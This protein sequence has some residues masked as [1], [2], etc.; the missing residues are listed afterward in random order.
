MCPVWTP[1]HQFYGTDTSLE[2]L[3]DE[4]CCTWIQS[5]L[6]IAPFFPP[7]SI[8]GWSTAELCPDFCTKSWKEW[9]LSLCW[10]ALGSDVDF[11][12]PPGPFFF[13]GFR[14]DKH[15]LKLHHY[16]L[17]EVCSPSILGCS[18]AFV[19]TATIKTKTVR[20]LCMSFL[21]GGGHEHVIRDESF[22]LTR[23]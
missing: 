21:D 7:S 20:L 10:T 13:G 14:S 9:K 1:P 22:L 5:V 18:P 16:C 23:L 3:F 8:T 6:K 4:I 17:F 11:Q 19:Y 15:S 2:Y 12:T